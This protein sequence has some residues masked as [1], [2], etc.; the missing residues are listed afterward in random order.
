[1]FC[2]SH[3][4]L[5]FIWYLA[6]YFR[7]FYNRFS[8]KIIVANYEYSS[9]I[10]LI[11]NFT[12]EDPQR[13]ERPPTTRVNIEEFA[14]LIP[15]SSSTSCTASSGFEETVLGLLNQLVSKDNPTT[16]SMNVTAYIPLYLAITLIKCF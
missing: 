13:A 5:L 9:I 6:T 15:G 8:S 2:H 7:F 4:L 12:E 3:H 1:M 14:S 16:V 10:Y 11:I